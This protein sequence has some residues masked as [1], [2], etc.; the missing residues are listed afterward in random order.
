MRRGWGIGVLALLVLLH[1]GE[2]GGLLYQFGRS[3][4]TGPAHRLSRPRPPAHRPPPPP[5]SGSDPT[6]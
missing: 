6:G 2:C 1:S 3:L 4:G 5:T